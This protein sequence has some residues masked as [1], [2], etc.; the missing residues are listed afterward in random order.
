MI[1][2]L[3]LNYTL[4]TNSTQKRAPFSRQIELEEYDMELLGILNK[5]TV[6]LITARPQKYREQTLMHIFQKTGATFADAFFNDCA[7]PPPQFKAKAVRERIQPRYSSRDAFYGI[8]SNPKTRAEYQ[9][10]G[11]DSCTAAEFKKKYYEKK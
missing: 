3:D 5:E 4:V 8:E 10:L 9:R 2:L 11:I 1:Y 6:I 7:L